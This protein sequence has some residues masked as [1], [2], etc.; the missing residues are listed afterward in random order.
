MRLILLF[1]LFAVGAL[2]QAGPGFSIANMDMSANPCI[3]FYQYA[4]G[5]WMA[6]NPIPADQSD[7]G[8]FNVLADRNR[9][10]LRGILDK[11]SVNDPKRSAVEQ[12]IGDFYASCMDEPA[13]DKLGAEPLE[14]E[15]KRIDAIQSKNGILDA[16]VPAAAAAA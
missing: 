5:T 2:A 7:W 13:I 12:K 4:C 3:D 14:A 16:L 8:T 11:A 10:V 9:A 1:P 6:N 15:L